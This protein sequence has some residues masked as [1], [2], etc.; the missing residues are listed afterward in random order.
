VSPE[1]TMPSVV[2][3]EAP[4]EF[5]TLPIWAPYVL[6]VIVVL[7]IVLLVRRNSRTGR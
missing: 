1:P 6:A 3:V 7:G 5:V 2:T 4:L